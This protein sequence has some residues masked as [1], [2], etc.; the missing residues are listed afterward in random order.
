M[1]HNR[2]ADQLLH[3]GW[4]GRFPI[5]PW[6]MGES[7]AVRR[8]RDSALFRFHICTMPG[9][10]VGQDSL[11]LTLDNHHRRVNI[12]INADENEWRQRYAIMH[13][14]A[15]TFLGQLDSEKPD[16]AR[17]NFRPV[18]HAT[19]AANTVTLATLLPAKYLDHQAKKLADIGKLSAFFGVSPHTI[20][21]RLKQLHLLP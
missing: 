15:S 20:R 3:T 9:D 8:Q 2:L 17:H 11:R 13:G 12:V 21:L 7:L 1:G 19:H 6:K 5:C 4:D 18:D 14:I 10:A 16:L